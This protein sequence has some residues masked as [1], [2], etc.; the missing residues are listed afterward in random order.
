[1]GTAALGK[2]V[3]AR[4]DQATQYSRGVVDPSRSRGVLD[5]PVK[6]GDD[7]LR[8]SREPEMGFSYSAWPSMIGP[9][10]CQFSPVNR[11]ICTCSIG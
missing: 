3:I 6:P 11:I 8:S 4:L 1:M 7:S 5:H 2:T 10:S 9:N